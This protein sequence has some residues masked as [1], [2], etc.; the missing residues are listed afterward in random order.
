MSVFRFDTTGVPG[1]CVKQAKCLGVKGLHQAFTAGTPVRALEQQHE[2]IPTHM[3]EKI[4][5]RITL[6][7]G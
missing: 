6:L 2:I 3:P 7:H 5:L 4:P 1:Q